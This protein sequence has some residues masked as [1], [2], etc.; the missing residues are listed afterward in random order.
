MPIDAT[1]QSKEEL[2]SK[3]YMMRAGLSVI[4]GETEKIREGSKKLEKAQKDF[5]TELNAKQSKRYNYQQNNTE[6]ERKIKALQQKIKAEKNT[7]AETLPFIFHIPILLV[8]MFIG[9]FI[10]ALFMTAGAE[11]FGAASLIVTVPGSHV[12]IVYAIKS[13]MNKKQLEETNGSV[14]EYEAE[15]EALKRQIWENDRCITNIDLEIEA[16][17]GED[18]RAGNKWARELAKVEDWYTNELVPE[19]T[20]ISQTVYNT[21]TETSRDMLI[22]YDWPNVDLL[23]CYLETGRADNLKEALSKVDE[24]RHNDRL[25]NA[26]GEASRYI[27]QT[28]KYSIDRMSSMMQASFANLGH[29]IQDNYKNLNS[30]IDNWGGTLQSENAKLLGAAEL[31]TALLKKANESSDK[32]VKALE[33]NKK[34]W[35]A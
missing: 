9:S 16:F 25:V 18:G 34:Y 27:A 17:Y 10:A 23:I 22:E 7:Q 21:L 15:I 1:V 28:M 12:A 31:N 35:D 14:R 29:Q 19:S 8:A 11:T 3:L 13:F 2:L 5:D 26:I 24:Q 20:A 33:E 4:A 32:L 6:C 30:R